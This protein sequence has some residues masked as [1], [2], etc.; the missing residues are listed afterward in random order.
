MLE[1]FK[2]NAAAH[3]VFDF[4]NDISGRE[5]EQCCNR[6]FEGHKERQERRR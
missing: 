4:S 5:V 6:R 2:L 1:K 3:A